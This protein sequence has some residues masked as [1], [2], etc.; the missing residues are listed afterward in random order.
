MKVTDMYIKCEIEKKSNICFSFNCFVF[1]MNEILTDYTWMNLS[2]AILRETSGSQRYK[3]FLI[4][5][6][7]GPL[8]VC[9]IDWRVEFIVYIDT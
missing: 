2:I 5:L 1:K 9:S 3:C 8:A 6:Y 4:H 7:Q